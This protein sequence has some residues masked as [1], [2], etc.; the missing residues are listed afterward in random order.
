MITSCC[1]LSDWKHVLERITP[2]LVYSLLRAAFEPWSAAFH[3][4]R[5]RHAGRI[6]ASFLPTLLVWVEVRRSQ[7]SYSL[8]TPG[9]CSAM[10]HR[11]FSSSKLL[12][13]LGTAQVDSTPSGC[14][15]SGPCPEFPLLALGY[16]EDHTQWTSD[17]GRRSYVS[18]V[19]FNNRLS[20]ED[21]VCHDIE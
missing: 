14:C 6:C 19:A 4:D 16:G 5:C 13:F 18:H 10:A 20:L 1:I 8:R 11:V 15:Q 17:R 9:A 12:S 7:S 2:G 3:L 21:F